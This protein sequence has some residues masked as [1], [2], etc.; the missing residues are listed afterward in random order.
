MLLEIAGMVLGI[1]PLQPAVIFSPKE[2]KLTKKLWGALGSR[3]QEPLGEPSLEAVLV[4]P[5]GLGLG[6]T[7]ACPARSGRAGG[8]RRP[9]R[10]QGPHR[11]HVELHVTVS[12]VPEA[13]GSRGSGWGC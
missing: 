1:A 10:V 6:Q 7:P 4:L 5:A 11:P 9:V 13:G 8:V 2:V 3:V 12:P